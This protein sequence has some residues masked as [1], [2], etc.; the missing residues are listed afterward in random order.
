LA[1]LTLLG[2]YTS[3]FGNPDTKHI[4]NLLDFYTKYGFFQ[5]QNVR[6]GREGGKEGRREGGKEGRRE[7]GKEGR[8]E[9][10]NEGGR[11]EKRKEGREEY[12]NTG[13][14]LIFFHQSCLGVTCYLLLQS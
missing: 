7:G 13:R 9:G 5:R 6:R 1:T 12:G 4:H 2:S 14:S 3:I 10:V 8:R 11:S